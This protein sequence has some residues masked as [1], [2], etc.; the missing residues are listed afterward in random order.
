MLV[1]ILSKSLKDHI[2]SILRN[3]PSDVFFLHAFQY[4]WR[5]VSGEFNEKFSHQFIFTKLNFIFDDVNRIA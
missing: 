4:S 2:N 3:I 1:T 5:W